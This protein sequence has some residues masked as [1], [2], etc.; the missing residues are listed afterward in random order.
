M[1]GGL[2]GGGVTD[3]EA[4]KPAQAAQA[5]VSTFVRVTPQ[6]IFQETSGKFPA[7]FMVANYS[8]EEKSVYLLLRMWRQNQLLLIRPWYMSNHICGNQNS[9]FDP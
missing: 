5:R 1:G 3:E 7:V 2:D 4:G 8:F 9:Y 6:V